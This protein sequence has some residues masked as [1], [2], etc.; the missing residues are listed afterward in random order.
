[1]RRLYRPLVLGLLFLCL[2]AA[3]R[4][5]PGLCGTYRVRVQEDLLRHR[6]SVR[7]RRELVVRPQSAGGIAAAAGTASAAY[8]TGPSNDIAV[9]EGTEGVLAL[10]NDFD[11]D[12]NTLV[13]TP[14]AA[15][16]YT[17]AVTGAPSFDSAAVAG[18]TLLDGLGDDD[19]RVQTLPFD[20]PF[21]G[22]SYRQIYV[23]SDGNLTFE[24]ADTASS[25]RS[26]GRM[27]AGPPRLAPLFRDLDPTHSTKGVCVRAES[28]RF[29][30]S[31]V[32]VPEYAD[33]GTGR[34]QTFQARI[35]ADGHI[36][37]AWYGITTTSAVVGIAPGNLRGASSLVTFLN[38]S[39][40]S[41]SGAIAE[42]FGTDLE[43]DLVTVAQKFY[44][45]HDDAYDYLVVFNNVGV[46][47]SADSIASER[48]LRA[49]RTGVGDPPVDF[50]AQFGSPRRLQSLISM[51]TLSQ[52]GNMDQCVPG[53]EAEHDTPITVLAH[54]AGHLFL[55]FASDR[56][57]LNPDARPMLGYQNAHWSFNF[58]SDA[59]LL[60][61]NRITDKGAGASPRFL[62]SGVTQGYSPLD[63][64]LMGM[65]APD[66]VQP[67]H[68]LFYVTNSGFSNK[69]HPEIGVSFSGDRNDVTV[70]QIIAAEG[71]RTPDY[72]VAQRL[73]RLAFIL[74]VGQGTTPSQAEITKLENFRYG[75]ESYY[76]QATSGN[77][78]AET[79]LRHAL[80][81]SLYPAA[82]VLKGGTGTA[83][84]WIEHPAPGDL[85][86]SL[87]AMNG[88]ITVPDSVTIP[89]GQTNATFTVAGVSMGVDDLV[90]TPADVHY[91]TVHAKIQVA[92]SPASLSLEVVSGDRQA[93]S[94][95]VP[96]ASPVVVRV[97]DQNRLPYPGVKV[98]ATVTSNGN[99]TPAEAIAD[100]NGTASF[101]WTPGASQN[102]LTATLGGTSAA[103]TAVSLGRPAITAAGVVNA[104]SFLPGIAPGALASVFG[105]NLSTGAPADAYTVPWPATLGG[106]QVLL[107]GRAVPVLAVRDGQVNFLVPS[108]VAT[109]ATTL[110]VSAAD[111]SNS[112]DVDISPVAPGLFFDAA[113]GLGSILI[114]NTPNPTWVQP[115]G[116]GDYLEVYATGL[117]SV[118]A[119][120]GGLHVTD[121]SVTATIAGRTATVTFAGLAPG[122]V[123][124]YQVDVQVPDGTLSGDQPV[125]IQIGGQTSNTVKVR[126]K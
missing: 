10:P 24:A 26:L 77:G 66:Q 63:Q 85:N 67:P 82:G 102:R 116:P 46:R 80:Q 7:L 119:A 19:A 36:E 83:A 84:L 72:T 88:L 89:S 55:A 45:T 86:I 92:G 109:G 93:G 98:T 28:S 125:V 11:L 96:L 104:A 27:T 1:M 48:T 118:H 14:S 52:Y 110:Q 40:D 111:L 123:G 51:G 75:F 107:G 108:D 121:Q 39:T 37:F 41:Y 2:H 62:T 70:D 49:T 17:F 54:E 44:G 87:Q 81:V 22:K 30:V 16:Q 91:E 31:W 114:A 18:G 71:R 32:A 15:T 4:Q 9:L 58:N 25:E 103:V 65:R 73:F 3:A 34:L 76:P 120:S 79:E 57:P 122:F 42:R 115:A 33:Y 100:E 90:A 113:A 68:E 43:I 61:G 78:T 5:V 13:F 20:F 69:D 12:N 112:V 94:A 21:F 95:G 106:V 38:G 74:I 47:D 126:V 8:D 60:E 50:G 53:R 56:D 117:G 6:R 101:Q 97:V 99:V 59:S 124:L 35:Y 29:V 105:V 23:S 64:Y